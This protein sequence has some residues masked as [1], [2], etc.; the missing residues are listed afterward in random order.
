[1]PLDETE[2]DSSQF[3]CDYLEYLVGRN[4]FDS[5]GSVVFQTAFG[6]VEPELLGVN[7]QIHVLRL[8][9]D[10]TFKLNAPETDRRQV[11]RIVRFDALKSDTVLWLKHH[12]KCQARKCVLRRLCMRFDSDR[13]EEYGVLAAAMVSVS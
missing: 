1:M 8:E 5:S 13:I 11:Q 4:R 6:F 3:L 2:R 9:S 7:G 10:Q 12:E